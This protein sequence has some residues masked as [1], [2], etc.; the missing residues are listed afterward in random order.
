MSKPRIPFISKKLQ[1]AFA[2]SFKYE[3]EKL[4][5]LAQADY[6][7]SDNIMT[8]QHGERY[9]SPANE[10]GDRSGQME[11]HSVNSSLALADIVKS[12]PEVIY[13]PINKVSDAFFSSFSR[14]INAKMNEV[15]NTT[16][17]TV[18]AKD[19]ESLLEAFAASLEKIDMG[20]DEDGNLTLP[21]VHIH[22]SQAEAVSKAIKN[23]PPE[24]CE[25]IEKIKAQKFAEATQ[26]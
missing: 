16:G 7:H 3:I 21:T 19:H 18:N 10:L 4:V 11:C 2:S 5:R 12:N 23:A 9:E 17:N 24:L 22:P 13:L 8:F 26:T 15:T 14:M 25:R 6:L 20:L 1:S